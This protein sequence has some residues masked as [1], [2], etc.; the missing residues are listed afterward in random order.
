MNEKEFTEMVKS[1]RETESAIGI[2]DYNLT[3]KQKKGKDFSRSLYFIKDLKKGDKISMENVKSIRPGF[4]LHPKYLNEILGKIVL[5]NV[6][7][8]ERVSFDLIQ[9]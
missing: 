5:K 2:V 9:K 7:V 4:G 1:V 6:E 3:E 8:G